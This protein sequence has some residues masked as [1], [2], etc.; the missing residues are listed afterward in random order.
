M[1]YYFGC[2]CSIGLSFSFFV[3][4]HQY[5]AMQSYARWWNISW[6]SR[7]TK[8]FLLG[9]YVDFMTSTYSSREFTHR[10]KSISM[11]KFTSQ[12]VSA[13]QEGGNEVWESTHPSTH[14]ICHLFVKIAPSHFI[15]WFPFL[16]TL[17]FSM[18]RAKEIYFKEWDPQ[19]NSLPDN[20]FADDSRLLFLSV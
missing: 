12:E 17:T 1:A 14:L 9:S 3:V 7:M 13:L 11:A 15:D 5:R 20:R 6:F 10:V 8:L 18:Q 2:F 4:R 16:L 19:Y